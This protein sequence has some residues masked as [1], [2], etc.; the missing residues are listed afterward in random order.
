MT[1]EPSN[2]NITGSVSSKSLSHDPVES[3]IL[4]VASLLMY[5]SSSLLKHHK[6]LHE[7]AWKAWWGM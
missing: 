3:K 5:C 6:F 4:C 1:C 7:L 2:T